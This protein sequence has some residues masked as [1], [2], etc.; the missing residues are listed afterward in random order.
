MKG[1]LRELDLTMK[2]FRQICVLSGTDYNINR[3]VKDSMNL[4]KTIKL[5]KKYKKAKNGEDFYTWV[6]NNAAECIES[7]ESLMNIYSMF[8]LSEN[9]NHL[10]FCDNI[11]IMNGYINKEKMRTILEE[12]GF[13]FRCY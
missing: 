9:R 10:K 11:R 4:Q 6:N 13:V 8:D 12:D 3:G 7:C 2:E 5:F 1:I